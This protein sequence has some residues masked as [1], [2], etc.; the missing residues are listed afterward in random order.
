MT[1]Q[2]MIRMLIDCENTPILCEEC[3]SRKLCQSVDGSILTGAAVM[4][5]EM[6]MENRI[7]ERENERLRKLV[8]QLQNEKTEENA[9]TTSCTLP[10][11]GTSA[12]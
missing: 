7:L 1:V 11:D 12:M 8:A 5:E 4:L 9:C 3:P 2:E 6:Q 10:K